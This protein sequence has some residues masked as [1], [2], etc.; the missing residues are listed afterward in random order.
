MSELLSENTI[1]ETA[2]E[3]TPISSAETIRTV[4]TNAEIEARIADALTEDEPV[5]DPEED[6]S[7]VFRELRE[8]KL[9]ILARENRARLQMQ[10]PNRL[11]FYWSMKH[12]PFQ[13]LHRAFGENTGSYTLVAKLINLSRHTEEIHPVD[14]DG[15]WW[16]TVDSDSDYQ[17]EI[18]FYAPNRPYFRA[19]YSN[20]IAT[21]RKSPSKRVATSA[22]WVVSADRFAKVL[23]VSGFKQ[24]AFEV[25][26]AGD[27]WE[28]SEEATQNA[29]TQFIGE[30]AKFDGFYAEELRYALLAIASGMPLDALR[31][32]I[33]SSLFA[34][35]QANADK[36]IGESA[37][38]ALRD[39][40]GIDTGEI[41][42]EEQLSAVY[43]ASLINFPKTFRRRPQRGLPAFDLPKFDSLSSHTLASS[44]VPGR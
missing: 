23:D 7:P 13:V 8:P 19:I 10:T 9:P 21:P 30:E 27:D 14:A 44:S 39:H 28:A 33:G 38:S 3:L 20:T 12:N 31:W 42:E 5:H 15:N 18:G 43:G 40:F 22:D 32:K 16:F 17:A 34:L 2:E 1:E 25:A 11:Y 36:L 41:L 24:D 35:L 26:L 6:M 29:F 37:L 4:E